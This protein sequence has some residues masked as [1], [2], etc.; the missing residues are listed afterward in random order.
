MHPSQIR[1]GNLLVI[2]L[3]AFMVTFL[4]IGLAMANGGAPIVFDYK[5]PETGTFVSYVGIPGGPVVYSKLGPGGIKSVSSFST[6]S[7]VVY[8]EMGSGGI[9]SVTYAG[10]GGP[11]VYSN[12]G[13]GRISSVSYNGP[14]R[15]IVV[16]HTGSG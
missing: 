16:L 14:E 1:T 8:G 13:P 12:I 7:P 5:D 10:N 3:M 4:S 9:S 6:G 2:V 11:V 15:P